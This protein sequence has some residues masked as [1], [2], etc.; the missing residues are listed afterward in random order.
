M[1]WAETDLEYFRRKIEATTVRIPFSGCWVWTAATTVGYGCLRKRK[2]TY[3]AHRVS[4]QAFVGPIPDGMHVLHSCDTRPCVNPY[5]LS[6][7]TNVDN[8]ADSVAKGRRLGITRNRPRGLK[9]KTTPEI[10]DNRRKIKLSDVPKVL[11]RIRSGEKA[12]PIA[13]DYG[14]KVSLIYSLVWRNK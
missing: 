11:G 14:V 4:F 9:Y 2:K 6:L 7:G 12:Q 8:I 13:D 1:N 10:F 5:H 3:S